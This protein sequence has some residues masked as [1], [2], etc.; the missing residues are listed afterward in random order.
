MNLI[1]IKNEHFP[2]LEMQGQSFFNK[3]MGLKIESGLHTLIIPQEPCDLY[4]GNNPDPEKAA[5]EA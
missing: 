1:E 3:S 4:I 2:F 5:L